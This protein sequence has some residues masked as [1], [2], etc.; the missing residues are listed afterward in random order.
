MKK[1]V[2]FSALAM[3][4]V[5]FA[6]TASA[7]P[8]VDGVITGTEWDSFIIA[9]GDP[10]EFNVNPLLN[11]S[12]PWDI[13]SL[14]VEDEFGGDPSDDGLY[15]LMTTYA[16]PT[17]AGGPGSLPGE[18]SLFVFAIDFDGDSALTSTD[19]RIINFNEGGLG[20][21]VIRDGSGAIVGGGAGALGSVIEVYAP[22]TFLPLYLAPFPGAQ[23][24]AKLDNRGFE[25][26]D[27]IPDQGFIG[28]I[29]EPG[30]MLLLGFGMAAAGFRRFC[31]K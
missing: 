2:L 25:P 28:V 20:T 4:L 9:A 23:G 3:G 31:R 15:F 10:N 29:P 17:F 19:D 21:V 18:E 22:A 7:V 6:G 5:A 26:D 14:R 11:I 8:V 12:D 16:P 1:F 13:S 27:F 30:S 24:F